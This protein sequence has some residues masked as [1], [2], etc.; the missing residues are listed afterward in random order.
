MLVA[1][2][3]REENESGVQVAYSADGAVA[4]IRGLAKA[5]RASRMKDRAGRFPTSSPAIESGKNYSGGGQADCLA[6]R[7][8]RAR[9]RLARVQGPVTIP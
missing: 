9:E 3:A 2:N 4:E 8:R 1:R 5:I 7:I 6:E